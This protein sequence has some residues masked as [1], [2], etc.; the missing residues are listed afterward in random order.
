MTPTHAL[1]RLVTLA[2]LTLAP[3]LNPALAAQ[4]S[5][6]QIV[7]GQVLETRD[8]EPY[9]YLRLKTDQGEQWA[10][11]DKAAVKKGA[12]ASVE[13]V[14]VVDNFESKALRKTFSSIIFGNLAGAAPGATNPHAGLA[15]IAGMGPLKLAKATGA[16]AY[17]VAEIIGQASQLNNQPV[18]LSGKVVKVNLDIMGKNWLHLQDGSGNAAHATHDLLVTTTG[19]AKLGDVVTA[20]G[21]VHTNVDL[22]M[23]YS[24]KVLID[25]ATLTRP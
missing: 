21:T 20:A 24:Y 7:S 16:N 6:G 5:A 1:T 4:P 8:A 22:G 13:V 25:N 3:W 18:R 10:V 11:V 2:L 17:T 14:M 9:T 19:L 15:N 23:G 12:S